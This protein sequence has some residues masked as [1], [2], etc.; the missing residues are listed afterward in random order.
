MEWNKVQFETFTPTDASIASY[1][2]ERR[3][4]SEFLFFALGNWSNDAEASFSSSGCTGSG[5]KKEN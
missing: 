4:Q 3:T 1:L 5:V 2:C